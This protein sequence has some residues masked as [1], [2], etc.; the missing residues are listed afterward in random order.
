MTKHLATFL[1]TLGVIFAP[2]VGVVIADYFL[3]RARRP[4][5]GDLYEKD[6]SYRYTRGVNLAALIAIAAGLIAGRLAPPE[7]IQ[8]I[9]S[10]I[11]TIAVYCGGMRLLYPLQFR[12]E[13]ST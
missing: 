1:V 8:P 3:L 13:A 4:A 9:V 12:V 7:A 11:V 10:L 2:L 5:L 6:G